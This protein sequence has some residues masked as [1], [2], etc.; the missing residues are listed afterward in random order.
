MPCLDGGEKTVFS[1]HWQGLRLNVP[2]LDGGGGGGGGEKTVFS[3]YWQRLRSNV[4][5]LDSTP[6]MGA[7]VGG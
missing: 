4:P 7:R 5:C 1:V 6:L 3:V 2:C